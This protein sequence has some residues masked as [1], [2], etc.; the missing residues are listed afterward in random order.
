MQ[1]PEPAFP[2]CIPLGRFQREFCDLGTG[3]GHFVG[4]YIAVDIHR[5]S[6][7]S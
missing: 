4:H 6:E 1:L 3:E 5:G 7:R 2:A